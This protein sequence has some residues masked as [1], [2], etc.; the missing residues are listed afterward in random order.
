MQLK[1]FIFLC[2]ILLCRVAIAQNE[3]RYNYNGC[4]TGQYDSA[5]YMLNAKAFLAQ[6]KL[7]ANRTVNGLES[8]TSPY[9][10]K[11][12]IRIFRNTNQTEQAVTIAEARQNFDEMAVQFSAHDICFQLVGIDFIDD[13]YGNTMPYDTLLDTDYKNYLST[14]RATGCFTIFIHNQFVN[15]GSSGNAYGIPNDFVSIARW[16]AVRPNGANVQSIFAHEVG[17]GLGLYHTFQ[18]QFYTNYTSKGEQVTRNSANSC[19]SCEG[20]GDLCCDTPADYDGSKGFVNGSCVYTGTRKDTCGP[21]TYA[22]STIN[23]MSY[24]PWSCIS[25]TSTGF[26]AD[27]QIRMHATINDNTSPIF[28]KISPDVNLFGYNG[29]IPSGF[30][31]VAARNSLTNTG[32]GDYSGS[33]KVYLSVTNSGSITVGPGI[34]FRPSTNGISVLS[35]ATCN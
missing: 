5:K 21:T 35:I 31:I 32:T 1:F 12:F 17:H 8:F 27:Q 30:Y 15:S 11:C 10:I 23:I 16:A 24:M 4:T 7:E 9:L 3:N 25:A 20:F 22:P 14:K 13:D 19:Y 6:K 2:T 28:F 29:T 26:T 34:R 33:S 18:R